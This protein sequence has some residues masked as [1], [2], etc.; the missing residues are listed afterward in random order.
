MN[1]NGDTSIESPLFRAVIDGEILLL[2]NL[3][4]E[5]ANIKETLPE[6]IYTYNEENETKDGKGYTVLH[7]AARFDQ[8][9]V[10]SLLHLGADINAKDD[11]GKTALDLAN[12][13]AQANATTTASEKETTL[14]DII[15][16]YLAVKLDIITGVNPKSLGELK[17]EFDELTTASSYLR[18]QLRNLKAKGEDIEEAI[19]GALDQ[20]AQEKI[21][22]LIQ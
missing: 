1:F 13:L 15:L 6:D 19:Q 7:A 9:L 21:P 16:N 11:K 17:T 4:K 22:K 8:P 5:G 3:V 10:Q 14:I 20:K 12:D 18:Y 2:S